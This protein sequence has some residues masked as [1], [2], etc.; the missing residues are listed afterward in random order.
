M[1]ATPGITDERDR[2]WTIVGYRLD[3]ETGLTEP[4]VGGM[5][6]YNWEITGSTKNVA[7]WCRYGG[8]AHYWLKRFQGWGWR[9]TVEE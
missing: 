4:F 5:T 9:V 7:E 2:H 8:N 1:G 3:Y 6:D